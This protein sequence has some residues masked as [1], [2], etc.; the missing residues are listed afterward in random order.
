M[1]DV[2]KFIPVNFMNRQFS[3]CRYF[4]S[5]RI[6]AGPNTASLIQF[7]YPMFKGFF[8]IQTPCLYHPPTSTNDQVI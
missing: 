4:V 5:S 7:V 3:Y 2:L 8:V 6:E 1:N